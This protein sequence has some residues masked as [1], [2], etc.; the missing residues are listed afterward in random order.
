MLVDLEVIVVLPVMS[1]H[2]TMLAYCVSHQRDGA[3]NTMRVPK[4]MF[5]AVNRELLP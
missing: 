4:L 5:T 1:H 2:V 3:Y